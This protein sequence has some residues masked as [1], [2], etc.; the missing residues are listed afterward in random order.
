M[1]D[2]QLALGC[3][4]QRKWEEKNQAACQAEIW[5]SR[6]CATECIHAYVHAHESTDNSVRVNK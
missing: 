6:L 4:A 3:W 2:F 1:T 5:Q